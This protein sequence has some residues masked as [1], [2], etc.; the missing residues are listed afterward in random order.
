[1]IDSKRALQQIDAVLTPL[2]DLAVERPARGWIAA[3][4]TALGMSTYQ[5][6]RRIG[7]SQPTLAKLEQR[8]AT[9]SITLESLRKSADALECDVFY[10]IIPRRPLLEMVRA[11]ALRVARVQIGPIA[12]SMR[13]VSQAVSDASLEARVSELAEELVARRRNILW[14]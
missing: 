4:R 13:L 14:R 8:E 1:M 10:A 6:A 2:R 12:H 5:L 3:V 7:I 9:G 11:Q